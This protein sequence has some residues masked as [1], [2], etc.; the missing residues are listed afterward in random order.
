METDKGSWLFLILS[1]KKLDYCS[2]LGPYIAT[3]SSIN[4]QLIGQFLDSVGT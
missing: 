4:Y 2:K 3:S 1:G